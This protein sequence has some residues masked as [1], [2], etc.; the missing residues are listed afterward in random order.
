MFEL[1][2]EC[3]FK[4]GHCYIPA[5]CHKKYSVRQLTTRQVFSI[6]DQLR[7]AGCL[8]LGL[9]GGEPFARSDCLDI[10]GYAVRRGL[11]VIVNTNASLLDKRK[12]DRLADLALNK[13]DIT[14]P[15]MSREVFE[16]VTGVR[17]HHAAVF[18]NIELL[19]KRKVPLGFKSCLLKANFS[20]TPSIKKFCRSLKALHRLDD[21]LLFRLDGSAEPFLYRYEAAKCKGRSPA[22]GNAGCGAEARHRRAFFPC[23][24]GTTQAAITP[25]GELKPCLM[26]TEPAFD[27]LKMGLPAAWKNVRRFI[28]S[29]KPKRP[30]E[31]RTCDIKPYCTWCP[32]RGWLYRKDFS[33]C[34]PYLREGLR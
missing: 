8:Y 17:G 10:I 12:I 14:I 23:Q 15:G 26:I 18:K 11:Q 2:Y 30:A 7:D 34:D 5:S 4:C 27:I 3:N 22:R 25:A 20:E 1:T 9:T 6:L 19:H 16:Q 21:G 29:I 13:I 24:T 32:A 28:Y 33:S 31:C